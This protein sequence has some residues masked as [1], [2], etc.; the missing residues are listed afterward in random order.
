MKELFIE[1]DNLIRIALTEDG[2][3]TYLRF[4]DSGKAII[5]KDVISGRIKSIN[6]GLNSVFIDIGGRKN[7]FIYQR[8]RRKLDKYKVGNLITVEVIRGELGDKGAKVTDRFSISS[9]YFAL[10]EG[11]G[12][13]FSKNADI[14]NI[15]QK[16]ANNLEHE[17]D[18]IQITYRRA[19]EG[20]SLKEFLK[21][22][23]K[24]LEKF[25]EILI[26][27]RNTSVIKKHYSRI[28]VI[29]RVVEENPDIVICHCDSEDIMKYLSDISDIPCELF[30]GNNLFDKYGLEKQVE[31]TTSKKVILKNGGN[32]VID[33]TEAMTVIDVNSSR[34][35]SSDKEALA[36]ETNLL[37]VDEIHRQVNMR[38]ISGI[39]V[40]DMISMENTQSMETINQLATEM[41]SHDTEFTRVYPLNELNLLQIARKKEGKP[42]SDYLTSKNYEKTVLLSMDY[43]IKLIKIELEKQLKNYDSKKFLISIDYSYQ[44]NFEPHQSKIEEELKELVD[45]DI[46]FEYRYLKDRFRVK[47]FIIGSDSDN[48]LKNKF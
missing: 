46:F 7:A 34:G 41:F 24:I 38:N 40:C 43:L 14:S 31:R 25:N 37:A 44:R 3:L 27:S 30:K 32:I 6:Q 17:F 19:C 20:L 2:N 4:F 26:S 16:F 47:P 5:E 9:P 18:G 48:A 28:D 15:K 13:K 22:R 45:V 11:Y 42:V 29:D 36:F 8:D 39:I 33:S 21:K 12:Y 10:E 1:K 35:I 23:N